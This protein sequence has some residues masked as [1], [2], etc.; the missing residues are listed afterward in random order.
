MGTD[1]IAFL[2]KWQTLIGTLL[3]VFIASVF[4][5]VGFLLKGSFDKM[6]ARKEARRNIEISVTRSI[7]DIHTVKKNLKFFLERVSGVITRA[8]AV[9]N[10]DRKYFLEETNIPPLCIF[11]NEDLPNLATRSYYIHNKIIWATTAIK[12]TNSSL[13]ELKERFK[14]LS[15][16]NEFLATSQATRREQ[17]ETY[18]ANLKDFSRM[19]EDF[20]PNALDLG[21]KILLE[22]KVHNQ[23]LRG[24]WG[25]INLWRYEGTSFKRFKNYKEWRAYNQ[26]LGC[27][28]RIELLHK[29]AVDKIIKDIPTI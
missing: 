7:N 8:E 11:L 3:G 6:K 19:I 28:D 24:R 4:S 14:D 21:T 25:F 1:F 2:Y 10:D 5:I 17:K 9:L 20:I 12:S 23:K 13:V 22:I 26:E 15:R 27:V 29:D 16:K 18:I